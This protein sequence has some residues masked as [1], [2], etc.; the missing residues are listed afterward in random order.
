LDY[1][2]SKAR[3]ERSKRY[4][5]AHAEEQKAKQRE[6]CKKYRETNPEKIRETNKK[7]REANREALKDA[8]YRREY[9]ISR[10]DK[11]RMYKEQR[12]LCGACYLPLPE[13]FDEAS[14]DHNHVTGRVRSLL[15]SHCNSV[16][17]IET[18]YP[19]TLAKVLEY[20]KRWDAIEQ[21]YPPQA[22]DNPSQKGKV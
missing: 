7:Y 1:K 10:F 22:E 18:K 21:I 6:R 8:Y 19:G 14:T 12:G 3:R 17:G 9:G 20:K 4:Y 16:E 13:N 5:E 2:T 11:E 15:H